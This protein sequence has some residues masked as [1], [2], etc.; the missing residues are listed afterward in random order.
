MV[1]AKPIST[2][3]GKK[4]NKGSQLENAIRPTRKSMF[5]FLNG[6][7]AEKRME[8]VEEAEKEPTEGTKETGSISETH[9][10]GF[11]CL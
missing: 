1:R 9:M 2:P 4:D 8:S 10:G 7:S 3:G 6:K 5:N 11:E